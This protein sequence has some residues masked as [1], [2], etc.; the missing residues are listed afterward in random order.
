MLEGML[1]RPVTSPFVGARIPIKIP[2]SGIIEQELIEVPVKRKRPK[3]TVRYLLEALV[4]L[5]NQR[6]YL[7]GTRCDRFLDV[8]CPIGPLII[9]E[10]DDGT[11]VEM[12]TDQAIPFLL[13]KHHKS[14]DFKLPSS[15]I[16]QLYLLQS[17]QIQLRLDLS[18]NPI[19]HGL[20]S[21]FQ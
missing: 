13:S 1:H 6:K 7:L 21:L 16:R 9:R 19:L 12:G 20:S 8:S 3:V 18:L 11:T 5:L 2:K 4:V 17:I 10:T 15:H 14:K